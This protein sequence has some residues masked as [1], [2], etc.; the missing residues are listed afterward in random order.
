MRITKRI[1]VAGCLLLGT[2]CTYA[3]LPWN[4]LPQSVKADKVLVTKHTRT[5]SICQGDMLLKTYLVSL[6]GEPI[7]AKQFEGDR[8]TPEGSYSIAGRNSGSAYHLALRISYPNSADTARAGAAGKSAG[9]DIMI[10]GMR[11]GLGWLGRWHRWWDW[12]AGCVAVT[13][14]E[15]DEL[16]RAVPDGTAVEI[17]P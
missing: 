1:F 10:H 8:R 6:G 12:T 3:W 15:M 5:L 7:G 4:R 11:N 2:A 16:W 13:N 17:R 9:G 14:A